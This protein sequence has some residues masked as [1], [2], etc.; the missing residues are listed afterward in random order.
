LNGDSDGAA[1]DMKASQKEEEPLSELEKQ[2]RYRSGAR[3]VQ[4]VAE[5]SG[6]SLRDLIRRLRLNAADSEAP[7]ELNSWE[8][9]LKGACAILEALSAPDW[10]RASH[11][12][13]KLALNLLLQTVSDVRSHTASP[14]EETLSEA[15]INLGEALKHLQIARGEYAHEAAKSRG[16]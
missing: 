3:L 1:A 4:S 5:T 16:N 11:E 2:R 9:Q 6:A 10:N 12:R 14:N 7:S 15:T 8:K 13:R